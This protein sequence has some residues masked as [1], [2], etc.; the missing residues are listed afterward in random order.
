MLIFRRRQAIQQ[1]WDR[2]EVAKVWAED[3]GAEE[4]FEKGLGVKVGGVEWGKEWRG[5]VGELRA[6]AKEEAQR[7]N[8]SRFGN[9]LACSEFW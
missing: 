9:A 3:V 5:E 6:K 1:R 7:N 4:R 8:V 2:T